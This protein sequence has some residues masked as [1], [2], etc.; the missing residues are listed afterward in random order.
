MTEDDPQT[1]ARKARQLPE[2]EKILKQFC[3]LESGNFATDA[4]RKAYD[5]M[6]SAKLLFKKPKKCGEEGCTYVAECLEDVEWHEEQCHHDGDK[7]VEV[8]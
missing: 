1:T 8:P 6:R 3:S 2:T 5:R 4:Y 7:F